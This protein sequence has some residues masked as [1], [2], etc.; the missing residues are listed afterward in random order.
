MQSLLDICTATL[1]HLLPPIS[2]CF[3]NSL[4]ILYSHLQTRRLKIVFKHKLSITSA[5]NLV[6]FCSCSHCYV[7]LLYTNRSP[8]CRP[9]VNSASKYRS[10]SNHLLAHGRWFSPG[11]PA[12]S[13]TKTGRHDIAEIL[14]KVALNT[15]NN[16]HTSKPSYI[17]CNISQTLQSTLYNDS[18]ISI[19][20]S[21]YLELKRII[22]LTLSLKPQH[23]F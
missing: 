19:L 10:Q 18:Q 2:I 5:A 15:K 6:Q 3:Q 21:T 12:S 1:K 16:K 20:I 9:L 11:T 14:L 22:A 23:Q 8:L 17:I 13:T 4:Q 7:I